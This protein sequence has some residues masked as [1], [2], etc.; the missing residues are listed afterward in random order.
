MRHLDF[1]PLEMLHQ[2]QKQT[3]QNAQNLATM[4]ESFNERSQAINELVKALNHQHLQ[5]QDL[6][7]RLLILEMKQANEKNR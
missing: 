7:S 1:D 5:L 2:L 6:N 4:A 3:L